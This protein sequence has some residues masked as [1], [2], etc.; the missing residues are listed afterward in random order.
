MLAARKVELRAMLPSHI[1]VDD[2]TR[3]AHVAVQRD[4]MLLNPAYGDSLMLAIQQAA[5]QG[6]MPDKK[7][8]VLIVRWSQEA[9]GHAVCWQPMVWGLAKLGRQTG[10]IETWTANLIWKGEPYTSFIENGEM[11]IR[12]ERRLDCT[13][14]DIG[15]IVGAYC[16]I[17]K[18][19]GTKI[20][21]DMPAWRILAVRDAAKAARRGS[22]TGPWFGPFWDEMCIKTVL[23]YTF[24]WMDQNL[25]ETDALRRFRAAVT[26]DMELDF[27]AEERPALAAVA[28]A[29]VMQPRALAAPA[30]RLS[31]LEA[32]IAG[33]GRVAEPATAAASE[34]AAP[35]QRA[36]AGAQRAQAAVAQEAPGPAGEGLP[37]E[38][39]QQ[40]QVRQRVEAEAAALIVEGCRAKKAGELSFWQNDAKVLAR[41]NP[42]RKEWP[43]LWRHVTGSIDAAGDQPAAPAGQAASS[44]AEDEPDP[45]RF[46]P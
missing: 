23:L 18:P 40:R 17:T 45:G 37:E 1:T 32:K 10:E 14:P 21:R 2:F 20:V 5:E 41:L 19:N 3:T 8:G 16:I 4:P 34:Q 9:G 38:D 15:N 44:P 42:L 11:V 33:G 28:D 26:H 39:E 27:D 35:A 43:Q 12:H 31:N 29:Q 36:Q 46:G 24:K 7:E 22:E 30:T 13:S 6:L 25:V